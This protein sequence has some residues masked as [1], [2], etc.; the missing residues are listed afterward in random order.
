MSVVYLERIQEQSCMVLKDF[1]W[2]LLTVN[3]ITVYEVSRTCYSWVNRDWVLF[4]AVCFGCFRCIRWDFN[5]CEFVNT[6]VWF[7]AGCTYH[8]PDPPA[9]KGWRLLDTVLSRR[10]MR[11]LEWG[12]WGVQIQLISRQGRAANPFRDSAF[13]VEVLWPW[14]FDYVRTP[15][16]VQTFRLPNLYE[17]LLAIKPQ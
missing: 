2:Y 14:S 1:N 5:W 3:E 17:N 7:T 9:G 4:A 16:A 13:S 11:A 15:F 8:T 12:V 6:F 10:V